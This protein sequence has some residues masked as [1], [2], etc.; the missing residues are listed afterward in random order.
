MIINNKYYANFRK[1][2]DL[3]FLYMSRE[4]IIILNG[5]VQEGREQY[6]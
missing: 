3:F 4:M 1:I 5:L 2:I 6:S